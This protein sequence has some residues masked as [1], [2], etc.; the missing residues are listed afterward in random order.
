M[1]LMTICV[2]VPPDKRQNAIDTFKAVIGPTKVLPGCMYCYLYCDIDNDD[3]LL[4]IEKWESREG[5]DRHV[6]SSNFSH[7][8]DAL[9]LGCEPPELLI[10]ELAGTHGLQ[11]IEELLE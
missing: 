4:L 3:R 11:L 7:I 5:F 2:R 10:H 1:I 9:E 6:R 8:F